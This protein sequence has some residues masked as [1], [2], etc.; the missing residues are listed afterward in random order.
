MNR[1]VLKMCALGV[2]LSGLSLGNWSCNPGTEG[3]K[4]PVG[5]TVAISGVTSASVTASTFVYLTVGV[6]VG[7]ALASGIQVNLICS[8]CEFFDA[9]DGDVFSNPD[10]SNLEQVVN[11]YVTQTGEDGAKHIAVRLQPP[12]FF[13]ATSYTAQIGADIGVSQAQSSIAV[14]TGP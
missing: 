7:G 11:P 12:S 9:I 2:I 1:S 8:N 14:A 10:P 6:T 3:F 13:G 4:A 5:S